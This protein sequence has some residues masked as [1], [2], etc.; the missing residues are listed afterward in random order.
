MHTT[1][2]FIVTSFLLV[3]RD[4]GRQAAL[5]FLEFPYFMEGEEIAAAFQKF[6]ADN[7]GSIDSAELRVALEAVG[8]TVDGE[9][10]EYMLRKYDDDR[11]ATLD[12]DEFSQLVGDMRINSVESMQARLALRSHS[13]VLAA[14]GGWW[15]AVRCSM[16]AGADCKLEHDTYVSI[17]CKIFRAMIPEYDPADALDTAETEW[18]HDRRGMD[19]L[20]AEL[21]KDSIFELADLCK[22]ACGPTALNQAARLPLNAMCT[23]TIVFAEYAPLCL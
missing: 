13:H 12:L 8:L 11:G 18:E 10:C 7:S 19:H 14:L 2:C 9:Q 20:D 21:F 22:R 5:V 17:M 6:D 4:A 16:K 23:S 3:L 1:R 15:G